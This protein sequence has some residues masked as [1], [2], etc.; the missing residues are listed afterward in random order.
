MSRIG[1]INLR[2]N[3][4]SPFL[5]GSGGGEYQVMHSEEMAKMID[6]EVSRIVEDMLTQTREILEQRRD[7]LEAVTQR[8]LEVEAI[9]NEE[10]TRLIHENSSGPWLVPGTVNAKPK[11]KIVHRET[12]EGE[13]TQSS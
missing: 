13:Q 8:L 2:R 12:D 6:K 10:L 11:A 5:A 9:D 1:R 4:R 7:V 3:T